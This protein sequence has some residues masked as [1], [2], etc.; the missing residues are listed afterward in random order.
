[1]PKP[2]GYIAFEGRSKLDGL[3]IVVIV[4]KITSASKNEKTGDLVQS[5]VIRADVDPVTAQANGQD[6]SIC[7]QCEHRPSLAR[8]SGAAPCYVNTGKSVLQVFKAYKDRKSV[9]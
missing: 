2:L 4:N 8:E 1:M 5:F 3:P 6:I 9:V 7:G